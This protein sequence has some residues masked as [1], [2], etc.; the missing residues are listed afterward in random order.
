ML[1]V[2]SRSTLPC[3]TCMIRFYWACQVL[4][5]PSFRAP[6]TFLT[7]ILMVKVTYSRHTYLRASHDAFLSKVLYRKSYLWDWWGVPLYFTWGI[8]NAVNTYHKRTPLR[9][10]VFSRYIMWRLHPVSRAWKLPEIFYLNSLINSKWT[11]TKYSYAIQIA[12]ESF[13][14]I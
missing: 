2:L 3:Y 5:V 6:F 12:E 1:T 9:T 11:R 4:H 8:P 14:T 13:E 7:T 10:H